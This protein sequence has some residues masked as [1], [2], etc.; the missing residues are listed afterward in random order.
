MRSTSQCKF[1]V[2]IAIQYMHVIKTY[3]FEPTKTQNH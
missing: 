2:K 1:Y 3:R